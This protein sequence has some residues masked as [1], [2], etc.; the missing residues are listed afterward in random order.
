MATEAE[1]MATEAEKV[2]VKLLYPVTLANGETLTQVAVRRPT[3]GDSIRAKIKPGTQD[4][5][6]EVRL[7]AKLCDLN[8]EDFMLL[9]MAD[10]FALQEILLSFL[11]RGEEPV[12][13]QE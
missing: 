8:V 1:K 2:V 11:G 12:S 9:D 13:G 5:E 6:G 4:A 10:Y 7:L 3:V